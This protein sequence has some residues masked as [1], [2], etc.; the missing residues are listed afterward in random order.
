M[1]CFVFLFRIIANCGI[2]GL[3]IQIPKL[4]KCCFNSGLMN[5]SMSLHNCVSFYCSSCKL[6][7]SEALSFPTSTAS[8][9]KFFDL[10]DSNVWGIA[11][12]ISHNQYKY[13]GTFIHDYSRFIWAYF[14]HSKSE[15]FNA[16]NYF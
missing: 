3:D 2:I 6:G 15:V 1:I 11:P 5:K 10:I 12:I 8:S 16:F 9:F 7:K 4:Y 14:L 13:F